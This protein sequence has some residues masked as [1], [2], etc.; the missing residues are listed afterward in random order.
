MNLNLFNNFKALY[1]NFLTNFYLLMNT[2]VPYYD[3]V[4]LSLA[5]TSFKNIIDKS[6]TKFKEDRL[7]QLI[8]SLDDKDRIVIDDEGYVYV[9]YYIKEKTDVTDDDD[10]ADP[11]DEDTSEIVE[12]PVEDTN[13]SKEPVENTSEIVEEPVENTSE[14]V[15]EP[16]ENTS[17]IVEEPVED[18]SVSKEPVEDTSVSIEPVEDTSVSK[19]PV[20]DTSE[21]VD[22]LECYNSLEKKNN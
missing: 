8:Y 13:V 11:V 16:V 6:K 12:E 18:T 1:Y 10:D 21:I 22:E 9:D 7:L 15:E 4:I 2:F 3:D 19:E 5:I 14:I 17:E 20:E